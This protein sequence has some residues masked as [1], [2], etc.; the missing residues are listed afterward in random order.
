VAAATIDPSRSLGWLVAA[1]LAIA[2]A[3][4]A[5]NPTASAL[6]AD[7]APPQLMGVY[8][9]LNSLCWAVGF[10]IGPPLGGWALDRPLPIVQGF[11]LSL[12]AVGGGIWI[13]LRVL[14]RLLVTYGARN[15]C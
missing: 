5:Y 6:T 8:T 3:L 11:W 4:A 2:V 10:A 1:M 7:I 15:G 9:S 13:L 14:D 12:V